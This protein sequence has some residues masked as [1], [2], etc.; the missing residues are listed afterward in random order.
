[1][2]LVRLLTMCQEQMERANYEFARNLATQ[3]N[4]ALN[5]TKDSRERLGEEANCCCPLR[6]RTETGLTSCE[7]C[8]WES[9]KNLDL[10]MGKLGM[11]A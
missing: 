9:R 7:A 3:A 2:N 5:A 6:D 1:M 10:L 8:W 4:E 11:A